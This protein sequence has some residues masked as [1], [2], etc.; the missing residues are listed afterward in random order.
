MKSACRQSIETQLGQYASRAE[1]LLA[2]EELR[3]QLGEVLQHA[4]LAADAVA[5]LSQRA[6][7]AAGFSAAI[8]ELIAELG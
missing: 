8:D 6:L 3:S 4:P 2:A 5:E 1:R 7:L